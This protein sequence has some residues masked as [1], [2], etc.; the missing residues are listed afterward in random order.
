MPERP[1]THPHAVSRRWV[2]A[3]LP[4][5]VAGCAGGFGDYGSV[6]DGAF[7]V[8]AAT[9]FDPS[10]RRQEVDW[11]GRERPGNIVVVVPERRLYLVQGGGR[12]LR[13]AVGVGRAE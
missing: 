2:V 3:G 9:S 4:L 5:L 10:L 6:Q 13:Y 1:H 8:P 11:R 12:A 7:T